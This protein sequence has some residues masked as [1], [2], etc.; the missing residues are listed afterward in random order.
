MA[1]NPK[2]LGVGATIVIV[3]VILALIAAA[4]FVFWL[5]YDLVNL[6]P[7]NPVL[8]GNSVELPTVST[9]AIP[10]EEETVPPTTEAP[11]PEHVVATAT[12]STQGDLLMP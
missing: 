4:G 10:T 1:R 2:R 9:E 5:C 11:V 6:Q 12:I 7:E 8:N 3:L